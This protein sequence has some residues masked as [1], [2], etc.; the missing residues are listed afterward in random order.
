M[1]KFT[2]FMFLAVVSV[3]ALSLAACGAEAT[4]PE[5]RT[6]DDYLQWRLEGEEDW[7]NLIALDE[8]RGEDG[9]DGADGQDGE[10]GQDGA[11]GQDGQDGE[12]GEDGVDGQSAFEIYI[13]HYPGYDG[14]EKEWLRDLAE[15]NLPVDITLVWMDG[16]TEEYELM[17]GESLADLPTDEYDWYLD[18]EFET[19]FDGEVAE[20]SATLYADV[21][22]YINLVEE[23]LLDDGTEFHEDGLPYNYLQY[24]AHIQWHAQGDIDIVFEDVTADEVI[25]DPSLP[26]EEADDRWFEVKY[27]YTDSEGDHTEDVIPVG[28]MVR[29]SASIT[30]GDD[31][32]TY[33]SEFEMTQTMHDYALELLDI[34]T[35]VDDEADYD[36]AVTRGIVTSIPSSET[37]YIEDESGAIAVYEPG[38]DYIV[39]LNVGDEIFVRGSRS[40]AWFGLQQIGWIENII[41]LDTDQALPDSVDLAELE[42][43]MMPYQGHR[44]NIEE[45]L[46]TEDVDS[47]D[48][49]FNVSL[50]DPYSGYEIT[51]RY[52]SFID[53]QDIVDFLSDLEEGDVIDVSDM[54]FSW[55]QGP[56]F[57]I[58]S[59]DEIEMSE[60]T[61]AAI[62]AYFER[63]LHP[64]EEI[65]EDLTLIDEYTLAGV[66]Y[67][68]TWDSDDETVIDSDT[69][70]V[71]RPEVGEDDAEVILT[72]T[73]TDN[74]DFTE[75][76]A[77]DVIV[78]A[79]F[80]DVTW[81]YTTDF[82]FVTST[83]SGYDTSIQH[84]DDNGFEWDLLGR[85]GGAEGFGLGNEAD[86]SFIEVVAQGGVNDISIDAVRMFTN[87][88]TRSFE[89]FVNDVSQGEYFVD[90]DSD[91]PQNFT[92][93]NIG[94]EGEVTIR[95]ESTSPGSR[96]AFDIQT[97]SWSTYEENGVDPTSFTFDHNDADTGAYSSDETTFTV[98]GYE[99]GYISVG[100]FDNATMQFQSD[101]G[102]L[103]NKTPILNL[104]TVIIT[105][106]DDSVSSHTF[107][108][109]DTE[110]GTTEAMTPEIDDN[111]YTFDFSDN[112]FEYFF[113]DNEGGANNILSIEVVYTPAD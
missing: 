106:Q 31:T 1:R 66:T 113:F 36:V 112:T 72:A 12:D 55:F 90:V 70:E 102:E 80:A 32:F 29:M 11:D 24:A 33:V 81:T 92:I 96:G 77:Y 35:L 89:V 8:L 105:F 30:V 84:T 53:D 61:D 101:N 76:Y 91:D 5:F 21:G 28:N 26:D 111:V 19:A 51:L 40:D 67:E 22:K 2:R 99:F 42:E 74:D 56:Q 4:E 3:F 79:E 58:T 52:S 104:Q 23:R 86:G 68:I 85:P 97:L 37:F 49:S 20:V 39:D 63:A 60:L 82:D 110:K 34:Q 10:D 7:N 6:T 94:I 46:V 73:V 45:L 108:G 14:D 71:T 98:E 27:V 57:L 17:K 64:G 65:T 59:L 50:M 69:G 43:D 41:V 88:N 93:Y 109:S 44:L 103:Y 48:D 9:E 54:L 16:A 83:S 25:F 100:T 95:I 38:Q 18:D 13:D 47:S 75:S 107:Y 15:G 78:L 62:N 87:S